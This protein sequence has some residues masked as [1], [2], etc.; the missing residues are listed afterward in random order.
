MRASGLRHVVGPVQEDVVQV[1]TVTV[2]ETLQW[3]SGS[4]WLTAAGSFGMKGPRKWES[5]ARADTSVSGG[6]QVLKSSGLRTDE[7][8]MTM[9]PWWAFLRGKNC[10]V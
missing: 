2:M 9:L 5:R 8:E 3:N 10:L 1:G 7:S 6:G 4:G